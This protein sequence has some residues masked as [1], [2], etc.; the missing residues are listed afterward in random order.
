MQGVA[1]KNDASYDLSSARASVTSQRTRCIP[2]SASE[3]YSMM[4]AAKILSGVTGGAPDQ[5]L[6]AGPFAIRLA[7]LPP[8][9]RLPPHAHEPATLNLVLDGPA[10][11]GGRA[12]AT[13]PIRRN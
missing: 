12:G 9:L 11:R 13:R 5:A 4:L 10:R 3:Y 8:G 6:S 2:I 1:A 7:R